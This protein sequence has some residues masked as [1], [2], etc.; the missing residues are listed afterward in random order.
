MEGELVQKKKMGGRAGKKKWKRQSNTTGLQL[1]DL[2]EVKQMVH[3]NKKKATKEPLFKIQIEPDR[4]IKKKLESDRF[5][6]KMSQNPSKDEKKLVNKAQ[7]ATHHQ[8]VEKA[9]APPKIIPKD[10]DVEADFDI[11]NV[12]I[13]IVHPK[14]DIKL[15]T[16]I[17][18]PKI[19]KPYEGQ[20]YNPS[21]DAQM[22]LMKH[23]VERGEGKQPI[24]KSKSDK[25]L[26]RSIKQLT[27]RAPQQKAK[28]RKE[29]QH[30]DENERKR[31]E[32]LKEKEFKQL[33]TYANEVKNKLKKQGRPVLNQIVLEFKNKRRMHRS[34]K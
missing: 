18:M 7:K 22:N 4:A 13:R 19:L 9:T 28:S 26:E 21:F 34:N 33:E 14:P 31:V 27:K 15:R 11:W 6:R 23:I 1:N 3:D 24:F 20:S 16:E 32:K 17:S 10:Q 29:R 2:K 25:A 8:E 5:K 12:D 30:L